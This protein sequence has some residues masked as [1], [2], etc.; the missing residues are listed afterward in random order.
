M[1]S[2]IIGSAIGVVG[3]IAGGALQNIYNKKE[4]TKNRNFQ[5]QMSNTAHQREVADLRAAG[6][7]P[8]LSASHGGAST[9]S[10]STATSAN[11]TDIGSKAANSVRASMELKKQLALI[12]QQILQAK[13]ATDESYTRTNLNHDLSKKAWAETE[14]TKAA[15]R[16][17]GIDAQN[18]QNVLDVQ[19]ANKPYELKRAE[20]QN[21]SKEVLKYERFLEPLYKIFGTGN[22]AKSLF[23][24]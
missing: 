1:D 9:P 20:L 24:N 11:L 6:L 16:I 5:A 15:T 7:N 21:D 3:D 14:Q 12:D 19:N 2:G 10:G 8:I 22:S 4:A 17:L 23:S 13:Q 18:R